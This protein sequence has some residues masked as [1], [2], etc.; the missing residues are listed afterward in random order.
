MNHIDR[1]PPK[2]TFHPSR[3]EIVTYGATAVVG[4]FAVKNYFD[5]PKPNPEPE[6]SQAQKDIQLIANTADSLGPADQT[7]INLWDTK[8]SEWIQTSFLSD[9]TEIANT[10]ITILK[11][12]LVSSKNPGIQRAN[13]KFQANSYDIVS[14]DL[15]ALTTTPFL[16]TH[17]E[18]PDG[19]RAVQ[20]TIVVSKRKLLSELLPGRSLIDIVREIEEEAF[21]Q[22]LSEG[23]PL[24]PQ[25]K[26][27]YEKEQIKN[28]QVKV[29]QETLAVGRFLETYLWYLSLLGLG[30]EL[31]NLPYTS[32][33]EH[34]FRQIAI[35]IESQQNPTEGRWRSQVDSQIPRSE[36]SPVGPPNR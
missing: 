25:E 21:M 32:A 6:L 17:D 3:R 14:A 26:V 33:D 20:R 18:I 1:E 4:Y 23:L 9:Q 22:Q 7:E 27:E 30:Q 29:D 16:A 2:H 35:Y 31:K 5:S 12:I 8:T 24:S 36:P 15:P 19:T 13:Y 34:N 11:D 10:R 28:R